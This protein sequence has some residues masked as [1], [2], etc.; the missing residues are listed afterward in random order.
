M[1]SPAREMRDCQINAK[2][3]TIDRKLN[4]F[5]KSSWLNIRAIKDCILYSVGGHTMRDDYNGVGGRFTYA[6]IH[7]FLLI[8]WT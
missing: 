1:V 8:I 5:T 6:F 3:M 7:S 4:S 2:D